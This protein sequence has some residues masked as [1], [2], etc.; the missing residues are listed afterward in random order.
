VLVGFL[1]AIVTLA[2][3]A[4][5]ILRYSVKLPIGLFFGVCSVL[6]AALSVV[7]AGHGVKALQ[8]AGIIAATPTGGVQIQALGIYPSVET[9][10]AQL[11]TIA[12]IVGAYFWMRA[13]GKRRAATA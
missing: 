12:I 5:L 6:M 8:E 9:L 2:V 4:W 13:A 1:S 11:L 7:F 10:A 3:T